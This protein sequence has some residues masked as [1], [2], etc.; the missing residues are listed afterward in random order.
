LS[1]RRGARHLPRL[2]LDRR[3]LRQA[4]DVAG[5]VRARRLCRRL[6]L[7]HHRG[8][9]GMSQKKYVVLGGGGSFGLITSKY[10]L[11]HADPAAVIAV[12]RNPPKPACFTLDIGDGDPRYRYHAYHVTHELD[13]LMELLDRERPQ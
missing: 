10:L 11:D 6:L 2:G 8:R 7:D 9:T 13:L 12:G 5:A 1:Q 4:A 3:H